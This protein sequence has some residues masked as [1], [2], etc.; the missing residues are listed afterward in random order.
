MTKPHRMGHDTDMLAL[1]SA[2]VAPEP[3]LKAL[4][5]QV[6]KK[7]L[8]STVEKLA[9][10]PTRNTSSPEL[11]A[12]CDWIADEFRALPGVEVEIMSFP[13]KAGQRV[14]VDTT[15]VQ[16]IATLRGKSDRTLIVGGH[17][18]TINMGAD[19][20]TGRAPGANDDASGVALTLE[21]ARIASGYKWNQ[22]L[23]F[24]AFSGEEQGLLGS[25][26]LAKRAKAEAWPI[27]AVFSNDMVGNS[28]NKAGLRDNKHVRVF[29]E[30][31]A[32]HNSRELARFI[33]WTVR[34]EVK[35]FGV[36]LVFRRDRFGRGGDHTPFVA[37]DFTAIRFVEVCEE[38]SHQHT[39]DDL[40]EHM[41]FGYLANSVR[42]NLAAF[43]SLANAAAPPTAVRV[44]RDQA[45]D[46]TLT[47]KGD[48]EVSYGVYWR[49]TTSPIWED[50]REVGKASK[51]KIDLVNKDDHVFAVGA[52]G[53][54]PVEAK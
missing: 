2:I 38:Y 21:M 23:K 35:G 4:L 22:T 49:K 25:T 45:H 46:T 50:Y 27:E 34:R 39:P 47:W 30:E 15:A 9:S 44:V 51:A 13:V 26:A 28:V 12:A 36:N 8:Q 1:L 43:S 5:N 42:A 18:D 31:G 11:R 48:P 17:I 54:I 16:V 37:E 40:P 53:G 29:S 6:D 20:L 3:D 33:E 24:V 32:D 10:F 41:D 52:L 14:P 19:P 7:R